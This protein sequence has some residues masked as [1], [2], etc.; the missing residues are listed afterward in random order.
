MS[1]LIEKEGKFYKEC[2]VVMLETTGMDRN[3]GILFKDSLENMK[4]TANTYTESVEFKDCPY[5]HLYITSSDEIKEGD[6][7]VYKGQILQAV[8]DAS[9][10]VLDSPIG[11][12]IA[13]NDPE[14]TTDKKEVTFGVPSIDKGLPQ[15]SDKFIQ[16][17]IDAYNKGEKIEKALVEYEKSKE[18]D[19]HNYKSCKSFRLPVE[20]HCSRFEPK[21]FLK[22]K[23]SNIIIKKTKDNWSRGEVVDLILRYQYRLSYCGKD[24]WGY[25]TKEW[26]EE[27]L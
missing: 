8:I 3:K 12:I 13:T 26:I 6:W 10:M 20:I 9:G 21:Y 2:G 14:L 7:Y 5:F 24:N 4:L 27:N 19:C 11:K 18:C 17:F 25:I 1:K 15:P 22:L 16:A 23:D